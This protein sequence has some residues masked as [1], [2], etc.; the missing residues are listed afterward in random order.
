MKIK[1]NKNK[2]NK[3]K[4]KQKRM[5]RWLSRM[6]NVLPPVVSKWVGI[7]TSVRLNFS[8]THLQNGRHGGER[9]S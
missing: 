5:N 7:A 1:S 8:E 4:N 2:Q 3:I 9:Q 6:N